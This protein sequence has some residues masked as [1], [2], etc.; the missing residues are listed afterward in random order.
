MYPFS[1]VNHFYLSQ[2]FQNRSLFFCKYCSFKIRQLLLKSCFNFQNHVKDWPLGPHLQWVQKSSICYWRLHIMNKT[3]ST[4][5]IIPLSVLE[6]TA[7][8]GVTPSLSA[9]SRDD[10]ECSERKQS[11]KNNATFMARLQVERYVKIHDKFNNKRNWPRNR[12]WTQN[13]SMHRKEHHFGRR[14]HDT[15][16]SP[17]YASNPHPSHI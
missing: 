11:S 9:T 15:I 14:A 8:N 17:S 3:Y 10:G 5:V 1:I 13:L 7:A 6:N 4:R 2:I 16:S 12:I